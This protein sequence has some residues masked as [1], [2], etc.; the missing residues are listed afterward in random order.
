MALS[1]STAIRNAYMDAIT[2]AVGSSGLIRIYA[3]TAPADVGTAITSQTLL[4]TLPCSATFAAAASGGVLTLNAVTDD[5]SADA[6][7]TASFFR[8]C[9]SGGTAVVQGTVGTSGTD[10]TINTTSV[11]S[12]GVVHLTSSTI[13]AGNV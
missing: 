6:T 12:G 5:S 9:T 1:F 11:V 2:T 13:T 8:I 4:A 7:G 10:M 3:G